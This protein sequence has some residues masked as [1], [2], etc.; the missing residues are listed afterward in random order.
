MTFTLAVDDFGIKSFSQPDANHLFDA[1]AGKYA[2]TKDWTGSSYL[3]FK[4]ALN[5]AA[6]HINISLPDYF[7]KALLTLRHPSPACPQ[8]YPHLWIA[9]VY[10]KNIQLAN[11]DLSP[12]LDSLGI[13]RVQQISGV[14]L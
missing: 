1:L 10:R 2:L 9:P 6:C 5:Y 11:S 8:H 7:P 3:G 13:K 12:L 14:F 4:I